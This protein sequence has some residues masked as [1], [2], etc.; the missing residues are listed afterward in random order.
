MHY[1]VVM[2]P[3]EYAIAPDELAR[4]LEERGFESVWFPEHTHIPAS[5]QSPWPGGGELPREYWSSYDPFVALTAAAAANTPWL[6]T[7]TGPKRQHD[8]SYAREDRRQHHDVAGVRDAM[9]QRE[10]EHH[11]DRGSGAP[12]DASRGFGSPS[13]ERRIGERDGA[14]DVAHEQQ[15]EIGEDRE[16]PQR[17]ADDRDHQDD[18]EEKFHARKPTSRTAVSE[19]RHVVEPADAAEFVGLQAGAA[20]ERAVDVALGHDPGDV[21]GL[22]GAAVQDPDGVA[23]LLA[24]HLGDAGTDRGA[25]LLRVVRGSHLAGADRPDG[26]V[27]DDQLDNPWLDESLTQFAT[28]QYYADEYG[29]NGEQG[30]RNALEARWDS[31]NRAEIPIGLPVAEYSG[32]EYS[33]IVYGRGPLFFV[34]LRERMGTGPFNAFLQEYTESLSWGIATPE[35]LQSLAEKHCSCDLDR[36]FKEW[37]LP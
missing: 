24:V 15:R 32:Q 31:V 28:L 25:H 21:G 26:L 35:V 36:L 20:D 27:G 5:R 22:D 6:M 16:E 1:G 7:R 3:T 33:A 9:E 4:G 30:F 23:S 17:Q 11:E 14:R 13:F 18:G 12:A 19:Q 34:A 8:R 29:A 37:V 2:F 10:D